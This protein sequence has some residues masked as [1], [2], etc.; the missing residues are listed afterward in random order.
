MEDFPLLLFFKKNDR[1]QG[2]GKW[3]ALTRS[4]I[5][6]ETNWNRIFFSGNRPA[7]LVS[8]GQMREAGKSDFFSL[9]LCSF[10]SS[11]STLNSLVTQTTYKLW[12][13]AKWRQCLESGQGRADAAYP[14]ATVWLGF[15]APLLTVPMDLQTVLQNLPCSYQRELPG[16]PSFTLSSQDFHHRLFFRWYLCLVFHRSLDAAFDLFLS[17]K[18]QCGLS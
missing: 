11:N 18:Q 13:S 6:I 5:T 10:P 16:F 2:P 8:S 9:F 14:S 4:T 1:V 7:A 3:T 12:T 15:R 17:C